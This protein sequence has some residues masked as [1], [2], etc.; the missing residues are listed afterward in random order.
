[1]IRKIIP[2]M[3]CWVEDDVHPEYYRGMLNPF[4]IFSVTA[5]R[6]LIRDLCHMRSPFRIVRCYVLRTAHPL[7]TLKRRRLAWRLRKDPS[8]RERLESILREGVGIAQPD[9]DPSLLSEVCTE[10]RRRAK[11][12]VMD[13]TKEGAGKG[14]DFWKHLLTEDDLRTDRPFVRLALQPAVIRVAS[15]YLGEVPHLASIKALISYPIERDELKG[16]QYWHQDYDDWKMIKLFI[17]VTDV[18]DERDGPFTYINAERSKKIP[19]TFFPG[20]VTDEIIKKYSSEGDICH[21]LGPAESAFYVDPASCYHQG[22][23]LAPGH[24]RI[25]YMASFITFAAK[26]PFME[27][28]DT[29]II[30]NTNLSEMERLVVRT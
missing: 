13:P 29:K 28:Y 27:G 6:K 20:T 17:Y 18:R 4:H 14:N 22:S 24:Y 26:N 16:S 11:S 15:A 10:L 3:P 2:L 30:V 1:M 5:W 12:I 7:Q 21:L 9:L 19:N 8:H 23:R 25:V